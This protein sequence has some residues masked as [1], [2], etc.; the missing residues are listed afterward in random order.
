VT[1][2]NQRNGPKSYAVIIETIDEISNSANSS[3]PSPTA[4]ATGAAESQVMT[5]TGPEDIIWPVKLEDS[6]EDQIVSTNTEQ[7]SSVG[8]CYKPITFT[9]IAQPV[10]A[11]VPFPDSVA[12]SPSLNTAELPEFSVSR[13]GDRSNPDM[14]AYQCLPSCTHCQ[15]V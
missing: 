15:C 12:R 9:P 13:E 6:D 8:R 1:S 4:A 11:A 10:D 14:N 2:V 5:G 3:H 7:I